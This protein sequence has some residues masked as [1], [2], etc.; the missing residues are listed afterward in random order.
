MTTTPK[1]LVVDDEENISF[2]VSS[3]LKLDGCEVRV[4]ATGR[5]AV[6]AVE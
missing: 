6:D 4:A 3:A 2:L 1:V 5:D